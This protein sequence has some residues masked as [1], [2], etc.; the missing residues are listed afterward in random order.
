MLCSCLPEDKAEAVLE[1]VLSVP[2]D[3][4][5]LQAHVAAVSRALET[6]LDRMVILELTGSVGPVVMA[7]ITSEQVGSGEVGMASDTSP[8][9]VGWSLRLRHACWGGC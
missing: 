9:C 8:A 1:A 7:A 6:A 3:K 2:E 4:G 5:C